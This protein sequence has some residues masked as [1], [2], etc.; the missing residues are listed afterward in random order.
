MPT[1]TPTPA[2]TSAPSSS[3]WTRHYLHAALVLL[4]EKGDKGADRREI[5]PHFNVSSATVSR[6]VILGKERGVIEASWGQPIKLTAQGQQETGEATA[7]Q[8]RP[9]PASTG[10]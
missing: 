5:A 2:N 9:K 4:H 10:P 7:R 1:P 6:V 3:A 8:C